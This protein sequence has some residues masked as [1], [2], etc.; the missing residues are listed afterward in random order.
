MT[1]EGETY[2]VGGAG[3]MH[4]HVLKR[5][6][7]RNPHLR[8]YPALAFGIERLIMVKYKLTSIREVYR[9]YKWY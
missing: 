1:I 6:G 7:V 8:T 4:P 3:Y 5:A 2:E 9:Y